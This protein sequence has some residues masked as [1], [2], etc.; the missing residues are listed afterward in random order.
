VRPSVE[1]ADLGNNAL[2]D[3]RGPQTGRLACGREA[4]QDVG[5]TSL[6][7][8]AIESA[9]KR[10]RPSWRSSLRTLSTIHLTATSSDRRVQ[11]TRIS[12]SRHASPQRSRRQHQMYSRRASFL[13]GFRG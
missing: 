3:F 4:W 6:L 11:C 12:A 7:S 10:W 5:W 8:L 9:L 2:S 13:A 1:A